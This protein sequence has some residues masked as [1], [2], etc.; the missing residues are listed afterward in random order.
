MD[1]WAAINEETKGGG[2]QKGP[3]AN[4]TNNDSMGK[5]TVSK[6][7]MTHTGNIDDGRGIQKGNN[8]GG[9]IKPCRQFRCE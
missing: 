2:K 8:T 3:L 6:H 4:Y 1:K 5:T 7:S 9:W